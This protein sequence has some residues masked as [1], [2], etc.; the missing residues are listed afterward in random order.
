[1]CVASGGSGSN[2][3]SGLSSGEGAAR[4]GE[5]NAHSSGVGE[6]TADGGVDSRASAG[7]ATETCGS[8]RRRRLGMN[9]R[10]VN[11]FAAFACN[12]CVKS[13]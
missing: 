10:A 5:N 13:R 8:K 11:K 9:E 7:S 2:S 3:N 4:G 6:T 1:M 12:E